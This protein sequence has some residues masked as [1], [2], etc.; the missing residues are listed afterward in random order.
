MGFCIHGAMKFSPSSNLRIPDGGLRLDEGGSGE[1]VS[2]V[3]S[4]FGTE[5]TC[6]CFQ[7]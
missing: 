1:L 4:T 2:Y 3:N 6:G 7:K 5:T